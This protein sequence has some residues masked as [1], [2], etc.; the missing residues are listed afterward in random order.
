MK[1]YV[2][3]QMEEAIQLEEE[4]HA[5]YTD[6]ANSVGHGLVKKMFVALAGDEARHKATFMEMREAFR[7][8]V[9]FFRAEDIEIR[10]LPIF[11]QVTEEF[12][13]N[14]RYQR[15]AIDSSFGGTTVGDALSMALSAERRSIDHYQ[16]ILDRTEDRDLIVTLE[17]IVTE[18]VIHLRLLEDQKEFLTENGYWF[19][20]E[21][22]YE[23]RKVTEQ[24]MREFLREEG[25]DI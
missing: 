17:R 7:N 20:P 3:E 6:R 4:G 12:E 21:E 5:F 1:E 18:E 11:P 22:F 9:R 10:R 8:K 25:I 23:Y 13:R 16:G 24:E 19:D 14:K 2:L 15:V